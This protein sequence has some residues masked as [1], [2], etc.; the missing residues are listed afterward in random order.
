VPFCAFG[1]A[2]AVFR[3]RANLGGFGG[4]GGLARVVRQVWGMAVSLLD[5][6]RGLQPAYPLWVDGRDHVLS[7]R[8]GRIEV[9]RGVARVASIAL[10]RVSEVVLCSGANASAAALRA[11]LHEGIPVAFVGDRGGAGGRVEPAGSSGPSWRTAQW[12]ATEDP[13]VRLALASTIVA[14]KIRN[15]AALIAR[16]GR[17][18]HPSVRVRDAVQQLR[19]LELQAREASDVASLLGIEGVAARVYFATLRS[20]LPPAVGFGSRDRRGGDVVNTLTNYLS[21][22]LK[23]VVVDAVVAAGLDPSM[24]FLHQPGRGRPTLAFDLMEE[25]RPVLLDATVVALV[26][27]Q[28]VTA[29]DVTVGA[30]GPRLSDGARVA[31]LSRFQERLAS[32][33]SGSSMTYRDFVRSQP[34]RLRRALTGGASYE[35]FRWR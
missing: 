2:K 9:R 35:C 30:D 11:L 4:A 16:W 3:R 7:L 32:I 28:A 1:L 25:W 27:L 8:Q 5:S 21:A 29:D 20:V 18:P 13:A 34:V 24:S 33:A 19:V 6:L 10:L 12:R 26:R 17:R 14:G 31:A 15:S 23:A 22:V